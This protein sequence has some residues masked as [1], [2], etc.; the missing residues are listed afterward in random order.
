MSFPLD[1]IN[2]AHQLERESQQP[3]YGSSSKGGLRDF[4]DLR[5]VDLRGAASWRVM[6]A[7]PV[8]PVA[9]L[10]TV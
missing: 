2:L 10:G 1:L 3:K 5:C 6:G 4:N 7:A 9:R 8:T